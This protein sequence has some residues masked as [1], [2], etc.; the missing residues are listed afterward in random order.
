MLNK[1]Q[2]QEL[3]EKEAVLFGETDGVLIERAIELFGEKATDY[4]QKPQTGWYNGF[5]VGNFTAY[6]LTL[7][8][9]MRA[10]SWANVAEIRDNKKLTK[11][12]E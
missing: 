2:V 7:T 8:G 1:A 12:E 6:Y 10:A 9:F 3:F 5:G 4:A 11:N